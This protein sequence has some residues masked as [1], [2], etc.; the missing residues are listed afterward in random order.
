MSTNDSNVLTREDASSYPLAMATND[1]QPNWQE[2]FGSSTHREY[3]GMVV[4][5]SAI[6]H[7]NLARERAE[8]DEVLAI[9]SA[10]HRGLTWQQIADVLGM[11]RQSAYARWA[12]HPIVV[13]EQ[14]GRES[15][16]QRDFEKRG[17]PGVVVGDEDEDF[18]DSGF[19]VKIFCPMCREKHPVKQFPTRRR[20]EADGTKL[21][22]RG[23]CRKCRDKRVAKRLPRTFDEDGRPK[24]VA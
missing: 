14:V 7:A 18:D 22:D 16:Q 24:H 15:Q 8:Q 12:D 1:A 3:H 2:I 13:R 17:S 19:E 21:R 20:P 5:W 10:R 23:E 9:A 11:T 4:L 6:A